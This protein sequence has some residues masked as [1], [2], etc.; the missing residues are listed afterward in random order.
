MAGNSLSDFDFDDLDFERIS[1]WPMVVKLLAYVIAFVVILV[2]GYFFLMASQMSTFDKAVNKEW[3]LR[4]EFKKKSILAANLPK[5]KKEKEVL[6]KKYVA[7]QKQFPTQAE[8]PGLIDDISKTAKLNG[9]NI[10]SIQL[11]DEQ[12]TEHYVELP[13]NISVVGTYHK[14][15]QFVSG[16]S[17]LSRIV[18][19]HDYTLKPSK[20]G[21][22][23]LKMTISAKTYRYIDSTKGVESET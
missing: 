15:A 14:V 5:L 8:V 2:L 7:L 17:G 22:N 11:G 18:T 13:I 21:R 1:T 3:T 4:D 20:V 16:I 6:A 19:L 9:L 23:E 10:E 12:K